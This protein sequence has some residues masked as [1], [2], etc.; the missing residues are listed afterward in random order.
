[1]RIRIQWMAAVAMAASIAGL[2]SGAHARA[3]H[4][5]DEPET[6]LVT[7]HAQPG[8]ETALLQVLRDD[9]ATLRRLHLVDEAPFVL[10]RATD[11]GGA[12]RYV[13][14]FTWKSAEIPDHAPP[15]VRANWDRMQKLVQPRG[16]R[17]GI[18]FE[19]VQL[20]AEK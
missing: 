15:E 18:D 14:I 8:Q 19:Q 20:L 16:G 12:V 11:P 13:E 3:A 5:S 4:A 7:F 9:R 17:P 10:A 1:M 2:E 6:V